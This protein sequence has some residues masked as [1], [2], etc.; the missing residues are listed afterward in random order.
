MTYVSHVA[1]A[2]IALALTSLAARPAHGAVDP[3]DANRLAACI[4]KIETAPLEA[5][6]D[7]LVW[8]GQSGGAFAE[9]C[10]ALARIANGDVAGG[11]S[12]LAGLASASDAG[13]GD[14]RALLLAKAANAWL[15]IEDYNAAL[16][17]LNAAL[18]LKPAEVDLLIDRARA[19]AGLNQWGKAQEDLTLALSKRP[20]DALIFRLRAETYVQLKSYD[21]ADRDVAQ[22]LLLAPRDVEGYVM[23]GRATEARRLGRVPD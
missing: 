19:L 10:I 14:N 3:R 1:T 13:D 22:A 21:A 20:S 15:M 8:R 2:L 7:G 16:R 23:R 17:A 18:N 11:A 9:Q 4:T 6:E 12:K 5:Y